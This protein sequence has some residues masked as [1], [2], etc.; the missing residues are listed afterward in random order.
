[1][2]HPSVSVTGQAFLVG[3]VGD[4]FPSIEDPRSAVSKESDM[5]IETDVCEYLLWMKVHN[6]A[7]TTVGNRERYLA[8][9]VRFLKEAAVT[10]SDQV[11]HELLK[12]Y[13]ADVFLHRKANGEPLSFGTQVQRLVPVQQFFSWMRR[14][15]HLTSNPAVD[16]TLPRP[17]RR[18]P[19]STLTAREMSNVLSTPDVA[20]PLGLRDRAMLE[21]FYSCALRRAELITLRLRDVDF[22]RGTVFV[23]SGKGAKDRY[24]PIGER[25]MFWLRL[26]LELVRPTFLAEK[27]T[28]VMFLSSVGTSI[29]P[30]WLS[31]RVKRYFA[32]AGVDKRGSCHLLRHTVATLMLEGGADIR[33]V[34]EML[35]HA[36]LETTQRYTR[37]SIDRLQAVHAATHPAAN[38]NVALATEICRVLPSA[39][40]MSLHQLGDAARSA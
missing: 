16:L 12:E 27:S 25:A 28:D 32:L 23:R 29:C 17:D 14:S 7:V 24:V 35:G 26:Y 18:L 22:D 20:R 10:R 33:Y 15:G 30:D 5:A 8:Y 6:Y 31:R 37:V 4:G 1:M 11:T 21:V 19:E 2:G 39:A 40:G 38:L 13:Q 9:L 36:R 3:R 34:A